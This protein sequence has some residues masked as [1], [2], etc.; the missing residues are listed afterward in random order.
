MTLCVRFIAVTLM[1]LQVHPQLVQGM[2]MMKF[3]MNH[4]SEFDYS[5]LAFGEIGVK[6]TYDLNAKGA[7]RA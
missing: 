2:D 3:L 7:G 1:H 6:T 4:P 5:G